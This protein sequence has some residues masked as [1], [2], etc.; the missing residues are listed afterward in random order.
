MTKGM[1]VRNFYRGGSDP[2]R[3]ARDAQSNGVGPIYLAANRSTSTSYGSMFRVFLDSS[4][5]GKLYAMEARRYPDDRHGAV[6]RD[7]D[8]PGG[9]AV[10]TQDDIP[11]ISIWDGD[12]LA[13]FSPMQSRRLIEIL[14]C[15]LSHDSS[16]K[17]KPQDEM[18]DLF[19][20][21]IESGE[22]PN[23]IDQDTITKR[24]TFRE[25]E[26][27]TNFGGVPNPS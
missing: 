25:P 2:G 24:L 21:C 6:F 20:H 26:D 1:D 12:L 9:G 23:S 10:Y 27:Q 7:W 17:G 8:T 18:A 4:R 3:F 11:A 13:L 16:L 19:R 5:A 22:I 14:R 15:I